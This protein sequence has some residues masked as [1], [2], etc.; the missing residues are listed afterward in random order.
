[1]IKLLLFT[2][3]GETSNILVVEDNHDVLDAI[4]RL[5]EFC[6]YH[7]K[8]V[9]DMNNETLE[10]VASGDYD[11]LILDIMLAGR[12]GRNIAKKFRSRKETENIPILMISASP[13][14]KSSALEAGANDFLPKPFGMNEMKQKIE[15]YL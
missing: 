3:K 11:L 4:L 7:A 9:K 2:K 14:L 10:E 1:M 15:Q 8:G 13:D 6:G 12:D 5:L